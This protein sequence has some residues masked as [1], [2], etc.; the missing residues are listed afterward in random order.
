MKRPII[1]RNNVSNR[2]LIMVEGKG[3]MFS[4]RVIPLWKEKQ[5][6]SSRQSIPFRDE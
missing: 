3:E 2:D 6:D 5:Y 1:R 4:G